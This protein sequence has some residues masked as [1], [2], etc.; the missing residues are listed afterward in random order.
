VA[1]GAGAGGFLPRS[2]DRGDPALRVLPGIAATNW[3]PPSYSPRTGLFYVPSWERGAEYGV[4]LIGAGGYGAVRALDPRTGD[5]MWEFR[6][7]D[8]IFTGGAL[9]TASDLVFTGVSG[10]YYTATGLTASAPRLEPDPARLADGY[11]YALDARTG[12]LLWRMSLAAS[13]HSGP[14]SY[15]V[16]GKQYIVVT[17]GSTL[18]AF[19][20]RQ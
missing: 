1:P 12:A 19:A 17:A 2:I 5:R 20:L 16:N 18:F 7:N 3:Y 14:M 8:A 10:D 15:A 9:T 6:L 13:I 11:F 4:P